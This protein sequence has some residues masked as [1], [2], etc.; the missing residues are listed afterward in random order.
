MISSGSYR[1]RSLAFALLTV[2][3]FACRAQVPSSGSPTGINAVF[4]K[5]FGSATA[6]EASANVRVLDQSGKENMTMPMD[7]AALDHKVRVR[8]DMNQMKSADTTDIDMLKKLGIARMS[9]LIRPDKKLIYLVYPDQKSYFSMPMSAEDAAESSNPKLQKTPLGSEAIEGHDCVKNKIVVTDEK[10]QT[11]EATT[12]NAKDLNDFP[13][14]IQAKEKDTTSIVRFKNVKFGKVDPKE[15]EPPADYAKYA[16]A[17]EMI[18]AIMKK[19][20]GAT[21]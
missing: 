20:G 19:S 15:F 10:G 11:M 2:V 16:D 1:T 7:F 17:S 3:A 5:L 21:K 8:I 18:Q 9:S 14:Q 13:V 12:W 4:M 6:F